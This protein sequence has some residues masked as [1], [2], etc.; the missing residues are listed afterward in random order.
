MPFANEQY[1]FEH[2]EAAPVRL[3]LILIHGAGGTHLSWPPQLRRLPGWRVLAVDLPGHGRSPGKGRD[4]IREYAECILGFLDVCGI[5]RAVLCGHSMGSAIAL[6]LALEHPERVSGLILVGAGGRLRVNPEILARAAGENTYREAVRL[7]T[8]YS[9]SSRTS[10][11]LV[12]L[13]ERRMAES[14]Q[15]VLY[16]DFLACDAF[17]VMDRLGEVKQRTLIVCGEDD[18]M[19]PLRYARTLAERMP[20]ARLEVLPGAGHMA[21]LEQPQRVNKLIIGFLD[22]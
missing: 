2:G 13:A 10:R 12:E 3:P 19:T 8:A 16:G 18:R 15:P 22:Q 4:S 20:E 7:V 21:M 5:G 14:P 1:Y 11:R 9:F 17:D 6:C